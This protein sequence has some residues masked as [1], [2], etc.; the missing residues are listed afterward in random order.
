MAEPENFTS[1]KELFPRGER[2]ELRAALLGD[3]EPK[4]KLT[5]PGAEVV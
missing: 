4:N 1:A 3:N 5:E 2:R